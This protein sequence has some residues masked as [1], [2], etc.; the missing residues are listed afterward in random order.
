MLSARLIYLK[1]P[2]QHYRSGTDFVSLPIFLSLIVWVYQICA[3]GSKRRIFSATGYVLAV[4]G[5]LRSSKVDDF[6]TNRK[7]IYVG[8]RTP[9]HGE[10]YRGS[11][12]VPF[13]RALVSSYR[14]SIV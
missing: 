9:N 7:R 2:K 11:G 6:G 14:Q 12:M 5:R 4:Q 1:W 8:L 13:E 3:L 10:E